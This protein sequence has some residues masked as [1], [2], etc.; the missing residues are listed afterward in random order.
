MTCC[1]ASD[2]KQSAFWTQ[3]AVFILHWPIGVTCDNTDLIFSPGVISCFVYPNTNRTRLWQERTGHL[4]SAC[5]HWLL[6]PSHILTLFF[7]LA[8]SFSFV[9]YFEFSG[10]L[11]LYT[12]SQPP[13]LRSQFCNILCFRENKGIMLYTLTRKTKVSSYER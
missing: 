7:F 2:E 10:Q 9:R 13:I 6:Q 3:S 4:G 1:L 12:R 5:R 8:I 11:P